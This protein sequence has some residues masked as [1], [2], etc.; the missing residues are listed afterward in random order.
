MF[1]GCR[2]E[3]GLC[4]PSP[5]AP[6]VEAMYGRVGAL[7]QQKSQELDFSL[8]S[9]TTAAPGEALISQAAERLDVSPGT[10]VIKRFQIFG[11]SV[12]GWGLVPEHFGPRFVAQ[13]CVTGLM[14]QYLMWPRAALDS[15]EI[16]GP[17]C[18]V[19]DASHLVAGTSGNPSPAWVQSPLLGQGSPVPEDGCVARGAMPQPGAGASMS[20]L[21]VLPCCL[22]AC[23]PAT[24]LQ[25]QWLLTRGKLSDSGWLSKLE[26]RQPANLGSPVSWV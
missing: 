11:L 17:S 9:L 1:L 16:L 6:W 7:G 23:L 24:P 4:Q 12:P 18:P 15:S 20:L 14:S 5:V 13:P 2:A 21:P 10:G 22:P 3:L 26:T 8:L 25:K 19:S